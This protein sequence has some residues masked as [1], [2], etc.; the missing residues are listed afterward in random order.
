MKFTLFILAL[1]LNQSVHSQ[2]NSISIITDRAIDY[3]NDWH[4][5]YLAYNFELNS[6]WTL[7][8]SVGYSS[9]ILYT[10]KDW[11]FDA[12]PRSTN[13]LENLKLQLGISKVSFFDKEFV[14]ISWFTKFGFS[15]TPLC[16]NTFEIGEP[17]LIRKYSESSLLFS[18]FTGLNLRVKITEKCYVEAA[19]GLMYFYH[20][21]Y[22][23]GP[24]LFRLGNEVGIGFK[25]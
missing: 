12:I 1:L 6:K 23:R 24:N 9:S 7:H 10:S 13:E 15:K 4:W 5:I 18:N 21:D 17:G 8:S 19:T 11:G 2:K 14:K 20:K 16:W 3:L 25:F 22:F